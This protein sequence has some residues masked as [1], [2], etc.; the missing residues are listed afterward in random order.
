[1]DNVE[2]LERRIE[3]FKGS[4]NR[5]IEENKENQKLINQIRGHIVQS[6]AWK[7]SDITDTDVRDY[8]KEWI[9]DE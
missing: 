3:V 1:M 9:L 7:A 4:Y 6:S 2:E 8:I 5:L